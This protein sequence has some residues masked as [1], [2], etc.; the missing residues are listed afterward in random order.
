[1]HLPS[2]TIIRPPRVLSFGLA[3]ASLN[4]FAADAYHHD[5]IFDRFY[6]FPFALD[7]GRGPSMPGGADIPDREE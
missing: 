4:A 2:S 6:P 5:K 1:M 3:F 7:V